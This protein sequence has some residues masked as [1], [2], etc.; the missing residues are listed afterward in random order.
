MKVSAN[1]VNAAEATGNRMTAMYIDELEKKIK[2]LEAYNE[3]YGE[4]PGEEDTDELAWVRRQLAEARAQRN[5]AQAALDKAN[6]DN[7][8]L[9]A[10]LRK[11]R[12]RAD[13]LEALYRAA[14]RSIS[15]FISEG[16]TRT[17]VDSMATYQ[18]EDEE[19]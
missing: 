4:Q 13:D 9:R 12:A 11:E 17:L 1:V 5:A 8:A 6:R 3:K 10:E 2:W 15:R 19:E 16:E 7:D 14:D 18:W